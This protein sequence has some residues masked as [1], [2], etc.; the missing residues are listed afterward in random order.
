MNDI[1]IL[2]KMTVN[3]KVAANVVETNHDRNKN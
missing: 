2:L 1:D 3:M